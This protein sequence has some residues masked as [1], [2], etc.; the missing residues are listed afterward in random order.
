MVPWLIVCFPAVGCLA[1][2]S[3]VVDFLTDDSLAAGSYL[4]D[5]WLLVPRP[6][7]P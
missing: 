7:G 4:L 3:L 2:S 5:R 6:L 1:V